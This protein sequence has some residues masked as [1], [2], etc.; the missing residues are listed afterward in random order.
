MLTSFLPVRGKDARRTFR[1]E[2]ASGETPFLIEEVAEFFAR[3]LKTPPTL[4]TAEFTLRLRKRLSTLPLVIARCVT[5]YFQ[6]PDV[7][8]DPRSDGAPIKSVIRANPSWG[9][10]DDSRKGGRSLQAKRK[11]ERRY[12]NVLFQDREDTPG[13]AGVGVARVKLFFSVELDGPKKYELAY[14]EPYQK[15]GRDSVRCG[16]SVF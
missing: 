3:T 16:G 7:S 6:P 4:N 14:I 12:D 11:K 2:A 15:T 5:V 10:R 9:F 1:E 8:L 13:F